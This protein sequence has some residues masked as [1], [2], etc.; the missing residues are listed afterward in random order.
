V[1]ISFSNVFVSLALLVALV[2]ETSYP[3]LASGW[4]RQSEALWALLK[5]PGRWG[6]VAEEITHLSQAKT[7]VT[8]TVTQCIRIGFPALILGSIFAGL[9]GAG[10]AIFG[11]WISIT[12]QGF[13]Q[14]LTEMDLSLRHLLFYGLLATF[15]LWVLRPSRG[16]SAT[17]IWARAIPRLPATNPA[18]DWW[19]CLVLLSVIN[20]LFF[21]IN[22]ID[23]FH[24]W[25]HGIL[26]SSLTASQYVHEGVN[27]LIA[28]VIL[29]AVVLATLFQQDHKISQSLLLKRLS[30]VWIVQ[31]FVLIAGVMLRLMRYIQDSMLT[32]QRVYVFCFLLLV[33]AG[34]A[35]LIFHIIRNRNLNWLI[36]SNGLAAI[37]LFFILQFLNIAGWV[38][39]YN[40]TQWELDSRRP[41]DIKYLE[42]LGPAAWPALAQAADSK[43]IGAR[44][45][46]NC[47]ER[48]RI[49][50]HE[51]RDSR[52][53]RSWQARQAF[54]AARVLVHR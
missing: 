33:A 38:A 20:G 12:V 34:F 53:W 32:L 41:L 29:S 13:W 46:R 25:L 44:A 2:G 45:A 40:V 39:R 19:R 21:V 50:E 17:R 7:G 37:A 15:S 42:T 35:L 30:Y 28:A 14:W 23:V 51:T 4:E 43:R 26:P 27:S 5:A 11:S 1:E 49:N 6:W 48:A 3:T 10:N 52:N 47:L 18:I 16:G 9:F 36:L 22:T 8:A 31:N 54:T 24:L